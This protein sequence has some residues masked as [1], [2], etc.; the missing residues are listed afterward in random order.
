MTKTAIISMRLDEET[1]RD[2][3]RVLSSLGLNLSTAF[4]MFCKQVVMHDGLPF[5][6]R[7]VR[8]GGAMSMSNMEKG[9]FVAEVNRGY[10]SSIDEPTTPAEDVHTSMRSEYGL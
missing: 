2:T 9:E 5:N 1:K 6:V 10:V 3:E 8:N 4:N 7:R